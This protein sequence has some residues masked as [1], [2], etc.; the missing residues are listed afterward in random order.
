V[1][2]LFGTA[3][4]AERLPD[5][6]RFVTLADVASKL[7]AARAHLA[8]HPEHTQYG[9][10]F[11]EI[12]RSDRFSIDGR[13]PRWRKDGAIALWFARVTPTG[14]NN[15]RARGTGYVSLQ[16]LVPDRA[17][18]EY[19]NTKGHYAQ[20]GDVTCAG[21]RRVSGMARFRPPACR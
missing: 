9:V 14:L 7:P 17:Y 13:E 10:S 6:L 18:V 16:L 19:M 15:G 2:L 1:Q 3:A 20:Y 4:V 5:G 11:L 12:A 8:A 21:T